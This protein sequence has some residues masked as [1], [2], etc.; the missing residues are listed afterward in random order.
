MMTLAAIRWQHGEKNSI[1]YYHR[2]Q[3][4]GVAEREDSLKREILDAHDY[5]HRH[6]SY[7]IKTTS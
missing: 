5:Q 3:C 2:E 7:P 1:L 6:F 4:E